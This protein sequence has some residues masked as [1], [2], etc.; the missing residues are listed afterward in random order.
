MR[1]LRARVRP[2]LTV[3]ALVAAVGCGAPVDDRPNI[4]LVITDDQ[5]YGDVGAHGNTKIR[6]PHL[7]AMHA[8]SV[9]LTNFHVDPTCSP[10]R[11][12]LVTG[13]YSSRTGVWHTIMGRSIVHRDEKT[14]ADVLAGA[15]YST[16]FFGKWHLGDTSPYRP[17]D[18][19]FQ[20]AVYHG[21]GGVGQ[22]PDYWGN[23]YFDDTYWHNGEPTAYE[24]YCTDVFFDNALRFIGAQAEN[25]TSPFFVYL[26]TNAP[27]GPFLVD[28][29]YSKPY[30]DAGVPSPMDKFYGMIENID[31]NMGRLR[32][33][34]DDLGIADNTLLIFM[35]DNG[36]AAGVTNT[37]PTQRVGSTNEQL[38]ARAEKLA[39]EQ[40]WQG[41]NAGMR[42]R[43]GS[44]YDGGHRVPFFMRWPAGS[45]GEPRDVGNLTAH[46]DVLPTFADIAGVAVQPDLDWDG[47]S[48]LP[49]L[50]G[51][52]WSDRTLTVHSQRIRYPERWRKSSVMT[53]R[54]RLVNGEELYDMESDPGQVRDIAEE[55]P[56]AVAMLKDAYDAWWGR[57][58]D[59]FDQHVHLDIG[60]DAENPAR[61]TA[62]D[63]LPPDDSVQVP[64]NQGH[65]SRAPA[66]NGT[67]NINVAQAG[68]YEFS[69]YQRD[70]PAE[71][72]I[73]A[74]EAT[75]RIGEAEAS[76]PVPDGASSVQFTMDLPAGKTTMDTLFKARDGSERGAFFVYAKRL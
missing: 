59:R 51:E 47:T 19:G 33:R 53:E 60:S 64:W 42:G 12:A 7:D 63:W 25:G 74:A 70:M 34:L 8:E 17:I 35:T 46:I 15:G 68:T 10:T 40:A 29:K 48:L 45:L 3:L 57:I 27:H 55:N 76:A 54:Y 24:G 4:I 5:G 67:W 56:E 32:A 36:T 61:I 1:L 69:L 49:L 66:V 65:V 26:S 16:A 44:E 6:T 31:D 11:S 72:P 21:G 39:D 73:E 75:L 28:E 41:F 62:H 23:D 38:L 13:R 9:R 20:E 14:F 71:F 18:R 52:E 50:R 58:D 30:A 43:K 22:T 2:A 37:H